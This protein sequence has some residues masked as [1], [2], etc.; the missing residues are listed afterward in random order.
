MSA[1]MGTFLQPGD[2]LDGIFR[3]LKEGAATMQQGGAV[4]RE[5]V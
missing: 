2:L 1:G 3:A 4:E 5:P